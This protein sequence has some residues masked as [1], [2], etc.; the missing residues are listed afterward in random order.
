MVGLELK[1]TR[2]KLARQT[3]ETRQIY[4]HT[5]TEP[6]TTSTYKIYNRYVL[7][8]YIFIQY[9]GRR[10][11]RLSES[12]GTIKRQL[13]WY[14]VTACITVCQWGGTSILRKTGRLGIGIRRTYYQYKNWVKKSLYLIWGWKCSFRWL[15]KYLKTKWEKSRLNQRCTEATAI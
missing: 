15:C 12:L 8:S 9:L 14:T 13:S 4:A 10:Q 11:A 3:T 5:L 1:A 2:A 6:T 7:T